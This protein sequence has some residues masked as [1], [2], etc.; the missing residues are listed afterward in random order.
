MNFL[1]KHQ[2]Q[3]LYGLLAFFLVYIA[4]GFGSSFFV[5][6]SPNDSIAE[7]DGRSIPLRMFWSHYQR[8]LESLPPG[9]PLDEAAKKQRQNEALR[10]LIQG[11]I[12]EKESDR[13]GIEVPD[14]QVAISL[15]NIPQL[16]TK[17]RFDPQ[18][19][20][21]ALQQMKTTP[22]DFEEEQRRSIAFFKLRYLVQSAVKMTDKEWEMAQVLSKTSTH[23]Q[24][25]QERAL[26]V[27]NQW[28]N[29]LGQRVRVKTH[30]EILQGAQ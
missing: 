7:V 19:Y 28:F 9:T 27:L 30:L 25:W 26:F 16:Q 24:L 3:I 5:K 6:G 20:V 14:E 21:K 10:D 1:R 17:G 23:D 13:Y 15:V 11:A 4:L 22:Q 8:S 2:A 12:F 18:L 29:Q